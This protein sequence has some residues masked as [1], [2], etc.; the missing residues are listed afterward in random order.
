MLVHAQQLVLGAWA[1]LAFVLLG[2]AF[3]ER[4][5]FGPP[6]RTGGDLWISFWV[7]WAVL[8]SALQIWHSFVPIDDRARTF[9]VIVGAGGWI[10][11]GAAPWRIFARLLRRHFVAIAACVAATVWLSNQSMAGPRFGDTGMY[12]VPT[13]HWYKSFAI[14]PGLANLFVPLGNNITYFLYGALLDGGPF[15]TRVYPLINT[16]LALALLARG[17]FACWRLIAGGHTA[18]DDRGRVGDLYYALALVPLSDILFSL[19]LTSPM[20]DTAVFL[21]GLLLAGELVEIVADRTPSRPKL[22]RFVFLAATAMTIKLSIAGLSLAGAAVALLW[23]IWRTRPSL[24]F[25]A[26]TVAAALVVALVP[27][28]P[29][30]ARNIVISGYPIYPAMIFPMP[31]DWI[32]RVDATAWIQRPMELAPLWTIFRDTAWWKSR[33]I[34]LGWDGQD[35]MRP[36]VMLAI[37]L[38]AVVIAK[39]VQWLRR[40]PSPIPLMVLLAPI[41]AF[42]FTFLNTPMPRY[43][44]ATLWMFGIIFLVLTLATIDG[45][46]GRIARALSV[47]AILAVCL[48]PEERRAGMWLTLDDFESTSPPRLHTE[49]LASGLVVQVPEHQ[50]CWYAPLPCTPEPHPGLRLR[51]PGNLGRGF[52]IDLAAA[53]AAAPAGAP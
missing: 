33:L 14:V 28:A 10:A 21:F 3:L 11:A 31:V 30:V 43:Q 41:V 49:T 47:V 37:G 52:A 46:A 17:L 13:I 27:V 29:W 42:V 16:L 51:E 23:W 48:V 1:L 7:G 18:N 8:L 38:A 19:Y 25:A 20:P 9:F 2:L 32:A 24:G 6:L 5:L 15:T 36:L 39:P 35:V 4:R 12:L 53:S 50:V 40:R 34:S 44:G 45:V 26:T 22:L